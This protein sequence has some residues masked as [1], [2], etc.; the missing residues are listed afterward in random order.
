M[1]ETLKQ[2][3]RLQSVDSAIRELTER[4]EEGPRKIQQLEEHLQELGQELEQ[5][6]AHAESLAQKRRETER[7]VEEV[8]DSIGK[9][10]SKLSLVKS[11]REYRASLKEIDDLKRS[12]KAKEDEILKI[13]EE[14]EE[15][16]KSIKTLEE[17]WERESAEVAKTKAEIEKVY[18][19]AEAELES[20]DHKKQEL[21]QDIDVRTLDQYD[22]IRKNRGGIALAGVTKGI[23][24]GCNMNL[25]PQRFNELMKNDQLMTCPNCHRIIYW[26]DHEDFKE[27]DAAGE[28]E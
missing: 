21:I 5:A 9:S 23:C 6:K 7:Q 2:L 14:Q 27:E 20:Y 3:I 24:T 13:M 12:M 17:S 4:R 16:E 28:E 8:R 10:Q 18:K 15:A 19:E 1:V 25:P 26:L 22:F 11:N